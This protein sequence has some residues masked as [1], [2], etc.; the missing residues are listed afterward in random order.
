MKYKN[1]L[2][3]LISLLLVVGS[4]WYYNAAA[5]KRQEIVEAHEQ[6]IAEAEAYNESVMALEQGNSKEDGANGTVY[7]DGTYEGTG[8]GFGGD[9]SVSVTITDGK[10][11]NVEI[12]AADDEDPAYF[13]MAKVLTDTIV[14]EQNAQVDVISGATFSSN[15]ILE[16]AQDALSKAVSS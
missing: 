15:G 12:L 1:F 3:R 9:V 16:A 10:I 2:I 5:W 7:Q 4:L 11:A 6:K 8:I 13:D 14:K